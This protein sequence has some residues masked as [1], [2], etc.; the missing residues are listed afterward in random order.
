MS[1]N[2]H[3]RGNIRGA[4]GGGVPTGGQTGP[5]LQK[6]GN[7]DFATAW[8]N[9]DYAELVG[10]VPKSAL[11]GIRNSAVPVGSEAA[12]LNL[13]AVG[14]NMGSRSDIGETVRLAEEPADV[15]GDW[16]ERGASPDRTA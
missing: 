15:V 9:L 7:S 3:K 5:A 2:W 6:G 8:A 4:D 10:E 13:P 11:P 12:V 16:V 1:G 14:G